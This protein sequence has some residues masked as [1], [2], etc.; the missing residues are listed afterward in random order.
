MSKFKFLEDNYN[1]LVKDYGGKVVL[2][3]DKK[4][5]FADKSSKLVLQFAKD[6]FTDKNWIITRIDSG[7]AALYGFT[8]PSKKNST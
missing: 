1:E 2:I 6:N 5:V 3:R 4:V 7:E 8:I